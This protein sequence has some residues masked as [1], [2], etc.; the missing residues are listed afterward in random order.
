MVTIFRDRFLVRKTEHQFLSFQ[1]FCLPTIDTPSVAFIHIVDIF[2]ILFLLDYNIFID[3]SR[4]TAFYCL[5]I[6]DILGKSSASIVVIRV[7]SI[8]MKFIILSVFQMSQHFFCQNCG[9]VCAYHIQYD[10]RLK[11]YPVVSLINI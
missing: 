8:F 7:I 4:P 6:A 9:N 11:M 5:H 3:F 2:L 1:F 10:F